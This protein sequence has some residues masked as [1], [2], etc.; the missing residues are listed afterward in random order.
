MNAPL[1]P[2]T[3]YEEVVPERLKLARIRSG[4]TQRQLAQLLGV[5]PAAV[6]Y[7]EQGRSVLNADSRHSSC[8]SA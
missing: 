4:M 7:W 8:K 1:Q 2:R 3:R 5:T 6:C